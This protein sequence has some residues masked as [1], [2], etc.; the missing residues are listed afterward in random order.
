MVVRLFVKHFLGLEHLLVYRQIVVILPL[1]S[2]HLICRYS[3]FDFR[4][5][6]P[7]SLTSHSVSRARSWHLLFAALAILLA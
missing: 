5:S 1:Q 4:S 3:W 6:F 7:D 2:P